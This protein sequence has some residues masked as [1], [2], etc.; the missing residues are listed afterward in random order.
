MWLVQYVA[1]LTNLSFSNQ[2]ISV[3]L[4]IV[5]DV[6]HNIPSDVIAREWCIAILHG[7]W[8][9]VIHCKMIRFLWT[10]WTKESTLQNKDTR[11]VQILVLPPS[12]IY[13]SYVSLE[14]ND[15]NTF[16]FCVFMGERLWYFDKF[17]HESLTL[18]TFV[19]NR[20]GVLVIIDAYNHLYFQKASKELQILRLEVL[21]HLFNPFICK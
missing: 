13:G 14:L 12:T 21:Q 1:A 10:I 17:S 4:P 15:H 11:V 2:I 5:V 6:V 8:R 19:Y 20:L 7:Y 18:L 16:F 9:D 3:N